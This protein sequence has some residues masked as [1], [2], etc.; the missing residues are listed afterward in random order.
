MSAL[1]QIGT[2]AKYGPPFAPHANGPNS[3]PAKSTPTQTKSGFLG[4]LLG[5]G[6][7]KRDHQFVGYTWDPHSVEES[8][9]YQYLFWRCVTPPRESPD[10]GSHS[11]RCRFI[12]NMPG[13]S[14]A[15][16]AYWQEQIQPFFDSFA[17]RDLSSTVERGEITKR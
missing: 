16:P 7:D 12:Y 5:G 10:I 15:K 3:K 2:L 13:L 9:V 4:G 8:P 11:T 14:S 1:S 17:E 6:K